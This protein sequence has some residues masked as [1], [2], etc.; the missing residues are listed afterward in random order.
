[1]TDLVQRQRRRRAAPARPHPTSPAARTPPGSA[2]AAAATPRPPSPRRT[3]ARRVLAQEQRAHARAPPAFASRAW[4]SPASTAPVPGGTMNSAAAGRHPHHA[5]D[6]VQQLRARML[7]PAGIMRRR[8]VVR[9]A[10]QRPRRLL[11]R[12]QPATVGRV[13]GLRQRWPY[14]EMRQPTL[15][16][17][18]PPRGS[19]MTPNTPPDRLHQRRAHAHPLFAADP[20]DRGAG[21]GG[22]GR[23]V[24]RR[25][26]ADPGARD[27]H[28]R[29]LRAVLAAAGLDRAARRP[30]GADDGVLP[31]HRPLDGGDRVRRLAGDAGGGAGGDRAVRRD[32]PSDRHRHAGRRRRRQAGPR[33]RRERR[34]RQSGRGVGTGGDRVPGHQA[35]WRAAFLAA[36]PALRRRSGSRGCGCRRPRPG[37]ARGAAVSRRSRGIWCAAR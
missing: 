17:G 11:E 8:V 3:G 27:R 9:I 2:R 20:A 28:V 36:G 31:R 22:A 12:A 6:R 5:G 10:D 26:W 16:R 15:R 19:S 29:A 14:V 24:R 21:H 1:M 7:V 35:G 4:S 23:A 33:H 13:S 34:V 18:T 25:V 30:A 37:A 32:L